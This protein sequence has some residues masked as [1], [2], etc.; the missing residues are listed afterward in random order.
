M[1]TSMSP[2]FPSELRR[3]P[4]P[5]ARRIVPLAVPG[6]I[7]R[8]NGTPCSIG[9]LISAPSAASANVTGTV[10]VRLSPDRPNTL[11]G[12]TC[13]RTY[14]SPGGPPRSPGAPLPLSLIRWPSAT[15]AGMRAWMVLVLIAP[16]A[17]T[18]RAGVVDH[19]AAAPAGAARLGQREPAEVLAVLAGSVTG[20]A[21]PRHGAR[22]GARAV[23]RLARAL[24]GQP[25]RDGGA[26]DGLSERERGLRLDVGAAPRPWLRATAEHPAEEV[27]EPPARGAAAAAEQVA[28]VEGVSALAALPAWHPQ[29]AAE[30]GACLVVLLAALVIRQ[31][32]VRLGDLLEAFLRR[33]VS[34][35]RVRVVFPRQLAVGLLDLVGGR[36]LGDAEDLVIVLLEEVLCAQLV[37]PRPRSVSA[38]RRRLVWR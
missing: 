15:P 24:G 23:T 3:N 26:V 29:P 31:D 22:L 34:L 18:H 20:R 37:P 28:Q 9:T 35:V 14:R 16:T 12:V 32:G 17:R 11:S 8:M 27:A 13:T 25:Q 7:L 19:H 5:L 30:Q 10:T 33:G 1:V 2:S 21:D 4:L 36:V 38:V 6:L